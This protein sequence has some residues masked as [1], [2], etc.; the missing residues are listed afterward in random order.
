MVKYFVAT[1]AVVSLLATAAEAR[2]RRSS[3]CCQAAPAVTTEA[4]QA[5][6][7][8]TPGAQAQRADASRSFSYEPANTVAPIG[9]DYGIEGYYN[10]PRESWGLRPASAKANGNY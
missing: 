4:P 3:C 6:T 5:P 8:P 2:G 7:A 9:G 1:L 10:S